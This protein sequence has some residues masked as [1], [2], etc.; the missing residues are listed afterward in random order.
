M[1]LH[2]FADALADAYAAVAYTRCEYA[3]GHIRTSCHFVCAKTK[4]AP[5]TSTST[6]RLE[7]VWQC[8][9]K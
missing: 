3:S 9:Q 4:G 5:L 2:V 1:C 6:P 7:A 8:R